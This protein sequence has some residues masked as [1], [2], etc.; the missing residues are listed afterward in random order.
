MDLY[1]K[2]LQQPAWAAERGKI[3]ALKIVTE[4]WSGNYEESKRLLA[5]FGAQ[6]DLGGEILGRPILWRGVTRPVFLAEIETFTGPQKSA[7]V[8]AEDLLL[9]KPSD[10]A[11]AQMTQAM[12][13]S[14]DDRAKPFGGRL[15]E[16][17][18]WR[19]WRTPVTSM[20]ASAASATATTSASRRDPPGWT[21]AETPASRQTSIASG[22]G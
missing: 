11:L 9:I 5:Q 8:K 21:K 2:M 16:R 7:L 1:Q 19:K 17:A 14:R 6:A 18:Q 15:P 3:L 12:D 4:A 10:V 20:V 13:A 22:N